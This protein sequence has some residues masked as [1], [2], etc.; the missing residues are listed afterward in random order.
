MAYAACEA[1][2]PEGGL[3]SADDLPFGGGTASGTCLSHWCCGQVLE[4]LPPPPAPPS[5]PVTL[6]EVGSPPPPPLQQQQPD[7]SSRSPIV[8]AAAGGGVGALLAVALLAGAA[9]LMRRRRLS[10]RRRAAASWLSKSDPWASLGGAGY[11]AAA[12]PAP[13]DEVTT[14]ELRTLPATL[15]GPTA[16]STLLAPPAG[17]GSVLR[18]NASPASA[19]AGAAGDGAAAPAGCQV[20]IAPSLPAAAGGKGGAQLCAA[21]TPPGEAASLAEEVVLQEQLGAGA[22]GTVYKGVW[23][24]RPVAVKV[25][26]TSCHANSRELESF[27]LEAR[28]LSNL[29]H[30]HIVSLLAACMGAR[31][32]LAL[33][34]VGHC[35]GCR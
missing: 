8:P 26:Q 3:D 16:L 25:L 30:P 24:G 27:R 35:G 32:E 21:A 33:C 23:Q 15:A 29:Q 28:L 9:L 11:T 5:V 34:A 18:P 22:F 7:S 4:P 12:L 31:C 19:A 14:F 1:H 10:Q 20:T 2:L 6:L 17:T 13:P